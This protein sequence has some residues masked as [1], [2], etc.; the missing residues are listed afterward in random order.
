MQSCQINS[1]VK[2]IHC[3]TSMTL[4]SFVVVRD[5]TAQL[6]PCLRLCLVCASLWLRLHQVKSPLQEI[7][8]REFKLTGLTLLRLFYNLWGASWWNCHQ[9]WL[10]PLL[11]LLILYWFHSSNSL[12]KSSASTTQ[13]SF[14]RSGPLFVAGAVLIILS[15]KIGSCRTKFASTSRWNLREISCSS[16]KI[17][18]KCLESST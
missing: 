17:K 10:Q 16:F 14:S 4:N 2:L 5:M 9:T 12:S 11:L 1:D 6:W 8:W 15:T 18:R 7:V 3:V 13:W